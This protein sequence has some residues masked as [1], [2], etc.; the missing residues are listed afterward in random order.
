MQ[1]MLEEGFKTADQLFSNLDSGT[2]GEQQFLEAISSEVLCACFSS[3]YDFVCLLVQPE[4]RRLAIL[5]KIGPQFLTLRLCDIALPRDWDEVL[6]L[7]GITNF[8]TWSLY[9]IVLS[10]SQKDCEAFEKGDI[11]ALLRYFGQKDFSLARRNFV[12]LCNRCSIE[13]FRYLI[14]HASSDLGDVSMADYRCFYQG[15][16]GDEKKQLFLMIYLE[17][18][19]AAL[20]KWPEDIWRVLYTRNE[21][22]IAALRE[23]IETLLSEV[24]G[25][26][27]STLRSFPDCLSRSFAFNALTPA[28]QVAKLVSARD[29]FDVTLLSLGAAM[30]YRDQ[31][32]QFWSSATN[33]AHSGEA[34]IVAIWG[35][36]PVSAENEAAYS[37]TLV[38]LQASNEIEDKNSGVWRAKYCQYFPESEHVDGQDRYVTVQSDS[39]Y[40]ECAKMLQNLFVADV[41]AREAW[42]RG[43]DTKANRLLCLMIEGRL[44]KIKQLRFI[45]SDIAS[46]YLCELDFPRGV[47]FEILDYLYCDF[48]KPFYEGKNKP[49]ELLIS[50]LYFNQSLG[51][52]CRISLKMMQEG[53]S[54]S[55]IALIK[56]WVFEHDRRDAWQLFK[57]HHP[58]WVRDQNLQAQCK[59]MMR[60]GSFK[61]LSSVLSDPKNRAQLDFS[62]LLLHAIRAQ[63]QASTDCLLNLPEVIALKLKACFVQEA[64]SGIMTM[65]QPALRILKQL[66]QAGFSGLRAPPPYKDAAR[67]SQVLLQDKHLSSA[68]WLFC[69][70]QLF[71]EHA[72]LLK[73]SQDWLSFS[74]LASFA[75]NAKCAKL[76]LLFELLDETLIAYFKT[77]GF[78]GFF[79]NGRAYDFLSSLYEAAMIGQ[80]LPALRE[81]DSDKLKNLHEKI[82]EA[83][84]FVTEDLLIETHVF[85]AVCYRMAQEINARSV[86]RPGC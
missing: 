37:K 25:L 28:Y 76:S 51:E 26:F 73:Q 17:S 79:D 77:I 46:L 71:I 7:L 22:L 14:L 9:D 61:L 40:L 42:P 54:E 20:I 5:Q 29:E 82:S 16:F 3:A 18:I 2:L 60:Y 8:K 65:H 6:P 58:D 15:L 49:V 47:S 81:G 35:L 33:D 43:C 78:T 32:R 66:L 39:W 64:V 63:S 67:F 13:I 41:A 55:Q 4:S 72:N 69:Y 27:Q 10:Y 19:Q 48:V 31:L 36:V 24:P 44:D 11:D 30:T 68:L 83:S 57:I 23:T 56:H 1:Q 84:P 38:E 59:E 52:L 34:Q 12:R 80:P 21:A 86:E 70:R 74:A 85:Q 75:R 50:A 53:A 62:E 45:V